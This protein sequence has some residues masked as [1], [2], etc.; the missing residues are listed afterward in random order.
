MVLRAAR[1]IPAAAWPSHQQF[2][3]ALARSKTYLSSTVAPGMV[4]DLRQGL[5]ASLPQRAGFL[6]KGFDHEQADLLDQRA[7]L[8][9][10]A[11]NGDQAA[12]RRLDDVRRRQ[13]ELRSKQERA[14]A[15]L[16]R[17]PELIDSGE[18]VFLAHALVLPST[19]P[20]EQKRHDRE[21][22]RIA[23]QVAWA[24]EESRKSFVRD[25]SSA[26]KALAVGLERWPGFDLLATRPAGEQLCIE[27]KGRASVGDIE[28][29]ENEWPKAAI[30]RDKYWLYVVYDCSSAHPRLLR[31]QD[32]FGKLLVRAK[33]G[34]LVDEAS[35]F[36]AA[37]SE[38]SS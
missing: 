2:D 7:R 12:A 6:V 27:A 33:R 37:E 9:D 26:E 15:V 1:Q 3:A 30:L 25:V 35:I 32:P 31:I 34:V 16:H 21:V 23:V 19:D 22:E 20:E 17:E 36:E 10:Q 14:L 13:Q 4:E 18:V 29:S 28:I 11:Q 5:M 24:Y 38:G 8:R